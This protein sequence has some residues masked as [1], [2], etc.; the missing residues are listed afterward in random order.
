MHGWSCMTAD[1]QHCNSLRLG[2]CKV[3]VTSTVSYTF[4]AQS[5]CTTEA[6]PVK[7]MKPMTS[8]GSNQYCRPKMLGGN[9]TSSVWIRPF[10]SVCVCHRLFLVLL[11]CKLLAAAPMTNV[12]RCERDHTNSCCSDNHLSCLKQKSLKRAPFAYMHL[13]DIHRHRI[14]HNCCSCTHAKH[15]NMS[16]HTFKRENPDTQGPV[17]SD[18][19]ET[20]DTHGALEGG[21]QE[22]ALQ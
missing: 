16:Q 9:L 13:P 6:K 11:A 8:K 3:E 5:F 15:R 2:T 1:M 22:Q 20:P 19:H 17:S 7:Y 14:Q 18:A 21:C 12:V 4:L 10:S